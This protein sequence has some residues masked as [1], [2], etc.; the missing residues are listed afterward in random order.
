[1][2]QC[3]AVVAGPRELDLAIHGG[4]WKEGEEGEVARRRGSRATYRLES[5][6]ARGVASGEGWFGSGR[7]DGE[8]AE[9]AAARRMAGVAW[10]LGRA[11]GTR[12]RAGKCQGRAR[13]RWRAPRVH[14]AAGAPWTRSTGG[15]RRAAGE[16]EHREER[17]MRVRAF[18]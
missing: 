12:V 4:R 6:W 10:R 7:L 18:L 8:R 17:E 13:W 5:T 3:G 15:V 14:L 11:S 16:T 9:R 1:M 2:E